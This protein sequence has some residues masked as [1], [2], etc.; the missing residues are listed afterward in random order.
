MN[1]ALYIHIPFCKQKCN[2]CD[3]ASF[4]GREFLIDDYLTAL[5]LEA[6]KRGGTKAETLYVGGGTPSVFS[7]K[8]LEKL[9]RIIEE[10]I[11]SVSSFR[12]STFEANPESLNS[13]KLKL[14]HSAG[15]NRLSMGLQS[16]DDEQLKRLGRIHSVSVFWE[17]F[18][19]A[20]L[21]GFKNINVDLIAGL[22]QQK[23]E[24]FLSGLKKLLDLKPEHISVYGLQ[25]EEGTPFFERGICCDQILM[26]RML[27]DAHFLLEKEGFEHYEISNFAREGK[28]S[29]HNSHYWKNGDYIG[30]GSSAVSYL[31]GERSQN[32]V[33]I[34]QYIQKMKKKETPV[35]F[36][37]KLEGI[38]LEGEKLML[39]FRL[40]EGVELTEKQEKFFGREIEKHIQNGL[41]I[42][43][44]KKVKLSFE[45]LFLANEV[46]YSFVAPFDNL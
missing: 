35:I 11:G 41:L 45:G 1:T 34:L 33:D 6:Q 7:E 9:I 38:A 18:S 36:S 26:R 32:T 42:K 43:V 27:E 31:N 19:A 29:L 21:A 10:N 8:Q 14:L 28:K 46:F 17:A 13:G 23:R 15:F 24:D 16:A 5:E 2:Y 20:R 3:F 37:E 22:P 30:L 12:E 25:I 44:G 39:G 4:A 40:L